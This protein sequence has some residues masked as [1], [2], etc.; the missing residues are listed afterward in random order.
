MVELFTEFWNVLTSAFPKA[1][2][3][4]KPQVGKQDQRVWGRLTTCTPLTVIGGKVAAWIAQE[5]VMRQ[6]CFGT[7]SIE[8]NIISFEELQKNEGESL[9]DYMTRCQNKGYQ[10]FTE[11]GLKG[12]QLSGR[13]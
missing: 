3:H 10:A 8:L 4:T 12:V 2:V 6:E 5:S 7:Q 11:F 9:V 13:T 1:Y